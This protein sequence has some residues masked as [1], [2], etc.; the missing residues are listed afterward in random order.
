MQYIY[1]VV[2]D[3]LRLD[4]VCGIFPLINIVCAAFCVHASGMGACNQYGV[5]KFVYELRHTQE[6]CKS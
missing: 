1:H 3:D 2:Q 4:L 6:A 5:N